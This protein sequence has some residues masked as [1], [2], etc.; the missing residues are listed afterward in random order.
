MFFWLK[1]IFLFNIFTTIYIYNYIYIY[2]CDCVGDEWDSIT[3]ID[4]VREWESSQ[5]GFIAASNRPPSQTT[6]ETPYPSISH[7]KYPWYLIRPHFMTLSYHIIYIYTY[8]NIYISTHT[9]IYIYNYLHTFVFFS[10]HTFVII[11][12]YI[13]IRNKHIMK[14]HIMK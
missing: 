4:G 2:T 10:V 13:S 11:C 3:E 9:Y 1:F 8:S 14:K 5:G 7:C 6:T 12:N